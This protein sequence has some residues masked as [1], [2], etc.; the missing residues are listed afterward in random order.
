MK[1]LR[2]VACAAAFVFMGSSAGAE[3]PP[4]APDLAIEASARVDLFRS[5]WQAT[6]RGRAAVV[7]AQLRS[8]ARLPRDL[9]AVVETRLATARHDALSP[10][11][12]SDSRLIEAYLV[13]PLGAA[14]LR[15]GKQVIAWGRADGINPTDNLSPRDFVTWLPLEDDQRFG[16][17]AARV[18][19][20]LGNGLEMTFVAA[21][22]FEGSVVPEPRTPNGAS[23]TVPTRA[24][25]NTSFA[26]KLDRSA[27]G[28][29]WSVSLLQGLSLLPSARLLGVD[30]L[31]P[32]LEFRH[33]RVRVLGAD[34]AR[35]FGR[36]GV[37]AEAAFTRP[38]ASDDGAPPMRHPDLFVVAGID[39]TFTENLNV[40]AQL[41]GRHVFN[42]TDPYATADLL[43]R[44]VAVQNAI[45]L[46][47]QDRATFGYS[48]RISD[49]WF[50]ETLQAELLWVDNRTRNNRFA[51]PLVSYAVDD[52]LRASLGAVIYSGAED[53]LF[54]RK[55]TN[56]RLFFEMRYSL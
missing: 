32:R 45:T 30:L 53:T 37:R 29:D 56:N 38:F 2:A 10:G 4:E 7:T 15:F 8:E 3:Q 55:R 41:F 39:R 47:Q 35:N 49:K 13:A 11:E 46:A 20:P 34:L 44:P 14:D 21:P 24:F 43:Q 6:G 22:W 19:W 50:G 28:L 31:G 42:H 26:I 16:T 5:P 51:R 48:L 9:R 18:K 40:N 25:A 12:A 17:W 23:T 27:T 33:D 36:W 1:R 54:G 52:H